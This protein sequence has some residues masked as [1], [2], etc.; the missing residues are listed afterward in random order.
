VIG[1]TELALRYH[2]SEGRTKDLYNNNRTTYYR[3]RTTV[4]S[5]SH[6]GEAAV[7]HLDSKDSIHWSQICHGKKLFAG[8]KDVE[9]W[10]QC[11]CQVD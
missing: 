10:R 3:S 7:F 11:G 2:L 5:L 1:P 4:D 6:D 8:L 9:G